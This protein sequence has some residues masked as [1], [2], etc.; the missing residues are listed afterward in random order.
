MTFW[1]ELRNVQAHGLS[2]LGLAIQVAFDLI[3]CDRWE[4]GMSFCR[5]VKVTLT[6][7]L[8]QSSTL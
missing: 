6:I 2:N 8:I 1:Q 7:D 5:V 3:N 4:N